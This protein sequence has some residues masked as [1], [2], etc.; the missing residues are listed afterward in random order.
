MDLTQMRVL[1]QSYAYAYD[2]KHEPN[3]KLYR[4]NKRYTDK[5]Q[6]FLVLY[7]DRNLAPL[8]AEPHINT[9]HKIAPRQEKAQTQLLTEKNKRSK[10]YKRLTAKGHIASHSLHVLRSTKGILLSLKTK[11]KTRSKSQ[12]QFVLYCC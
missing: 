7:P 8:R 5:K 11:L 3:C 12:S 10:L 2:C 4:Q 6:H 9:Q 1:F